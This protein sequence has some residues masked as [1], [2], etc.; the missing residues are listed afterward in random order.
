MM[1]P[2]KNLSNSNLDLYLTKLAIYVM[3][4]PLFIKISCR[5]EEQKKFFLFT[6]KLLIE[7]KINLIAIVFDF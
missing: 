2:Y 1:I 4:F 7:N 6:K 3:H 5:A